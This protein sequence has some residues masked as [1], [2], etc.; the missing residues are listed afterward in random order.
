MYLL[1]YL[2]SYYDVYLHVLSYVWTCTPSV[3]ARTVPEVTG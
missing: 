3:S 2:I 1:L